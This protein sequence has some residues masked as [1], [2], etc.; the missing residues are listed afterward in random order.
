M[1]EANTYMKDLFAIAKF[2]PRDV[3][4][5]AEMRKASEEAYNFARA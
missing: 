3:Q 1:D 2:D 4:F 5:E